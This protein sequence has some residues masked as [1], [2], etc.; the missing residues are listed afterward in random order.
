MR[1][2][3]INYLVVGSFVLVLFA[4]LMIV[5]Y[6]ITGRSGPADEYTVSYANVEGIKYGTPV[7]FEGYQIGQVESIEPLREGGGIQ[8]RITLSVIEGWQIPD[9]SVAAVVKSGLLS[10]VGINIEEGKS[11]NPHQPGAQ[12]KG[13]EAIDLFGAVSGLAGDLQD[14][15]RG[16]LKPMIDNLNNHINRIG[17]EVHPILNEQVRGLM[18]KLLLSADRLNALL[19]IE[20]L[21]SVRNT[22][23]DVEVSADSLR[24]LLAKI[25]TTRAELDEL[26]THTDEI[27]TENG[28]DVRETVR[29]LRKSLD[30]IAKHIDAIAHHMEGT[31]RNMQEFS[32]EIR[33]N[34]G[35]LLRGAPPEDDAAQTAEGEQQ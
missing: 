32:R 31:S 15:S 19:S 7:T 16:S 13:R 30:T 11:R 8:F 21:D 3:N 18:Q 1:R 35:A 14:L 9:D 17:D 26:L 27:V 34:P 4:L 25:E 29:D 12:L 10:A 24:E 33:E 6:Q 5:L 22:L 20:N 2:D 23:Q 28:V